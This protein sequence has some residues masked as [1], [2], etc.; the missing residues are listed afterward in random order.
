MLL[1]LIMFHIFTAKGKCNYNSEAK[2]LKWEKRGVKHV[3]KSQAGGLM[4]TFTQL[5][6]CFLPSHGQRITFV[7]LEFCISFKQ[8]KGKKNYL[9]TRRN[10]DDQTWFSIYSRPLHLFMCWLWIKVN[11]NDIKMNLQ[12]QVCI[13]RKIVASKEYVKKKVAKL[14]F[15]VWTALPAILSFLPDAWYDNNHVFCFFL[16]SL[17]SLV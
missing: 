15:D 1:N 10:S 9:K 8:S 13:A 11:V 4:V 17:I 12:V 7:P 5:L 6:V 16:N 14:N 3:F 2:L